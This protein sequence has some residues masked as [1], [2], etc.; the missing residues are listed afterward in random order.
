MRGDHADD[1]LRIVAQKGGVGCVDAG[2]Y[3]A[4]HWTTDYKAPKCAEALLRAGAEMEALD[5]MGRTTLHWAA[6]FGAQRT[7]AVLLA[8]GANYT[9]QDQQGKTA[10]DVAVLCEKREAWDAAWKETEDIRIPPS[11]LRFAGT[12][13]RDPKQTLADIGIGAESVLEFVQAPT[14]SVPWYRAGGGRASDDIRVRH[15]Q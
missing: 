15:R 13:L 8:A 11:L 1:V 3:T 14:R 6:N 5:P 7:I 2:G 12:E 4:L 9:L 10:E